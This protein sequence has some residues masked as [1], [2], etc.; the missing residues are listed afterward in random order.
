[1]SLYL[2]KSA[3][4]W[5]DVLFRFLFIHVF[6]FTNQSWIFVISK[7]ICTAEKVLSKCFSVLFTVR[8]TDSLFHSM[9]MRTEAS[10]AY[11][12]MKPLG[13]VNT[14]WE[15][16]CFFGQRSNNLK[17]KNSITGVEQHVRVSHLHFTP[18]YFCLTL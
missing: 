1:M 5:P 13:L 10:L 2:E 14:Q 15:K 12:H 3:T 18:V 11:K 17:V 7:K 9:V 16:A 4:L 6:L 8:I